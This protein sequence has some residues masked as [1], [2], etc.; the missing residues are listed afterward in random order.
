M[1]SK[2]DCASFM[3]RVLEQF[4]NL[5]TYLEAI[6]LHNG[7]YVTRFEEIART[8]LLLA[9]S[10]EHPGLDRILEAYLEDYLSKSPSFS[11]SSDSDAYLRSTHDDDLPI[12][13][14]H[15]LVI[16]HSVLA[17][18]LVLHE[19][20]NRVTHTLFN[21][22][23][24][25]DQRFFVFHRYL[26]KAQRPNKLE[27]LSELHQAAIKTLYS[28]N[29]GRSLARVH[30]HDIA[31]KDP[32]RCFLLGD[33]PSINECLIRFRAVVG[34]LL[35][36]HQDPKQREEH[37][38]QAEILIN[39]FNELKDACQDLTSALLAQC[40]QTLLKEQQAPGKFTAK[41]LNG[42]A[43][44]A[45]EFLER[46]Y[47]P[48]HHFLVQ[49][50]VSPALAYACL[51][52]PPLEPRITSEF[53]ALSKV[54]AAMPEPNGSIGFQRFWTQGIILMAGMDQVLNL[55]LSNEDRFKLYLA[56]DDSRLRDSITSDALLEAT[57][58][59]DLG[60]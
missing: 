15:N 40:L 50:G 2:R 35:T 6:H 16:P 45:N 36:G 13:I 32:R 51:I 23:A 49:Q 48:L 14:D 55:P 41:P 38:A 42:G 59:H 47:A 33:V 31:L 30:A 53:M 17:L 24:K 57:L 52:R 46:A 39:L 18:S 10:F 1:R 4:C 54:V 44:A 22:A 43:Q 21:E 25:G 3:L 28:N 9:L 34:F 20:S 27:G 12:L 19:W 29:L 7:G 58:T 26:D 60:L 5:R 11:W 56:F 37:D 8:R